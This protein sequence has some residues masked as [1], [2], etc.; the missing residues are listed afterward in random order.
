M[1]NLFSKVLPRLFNGARRVFSTKNA[2]KPAYP[3]V[4]E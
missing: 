1:A 2:R 4:N 3:H